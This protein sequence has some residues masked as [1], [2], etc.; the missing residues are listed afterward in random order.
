MTLPPPSLSTPTHPSFEATLALIC[1]IRITPTCY[2]TTIMKRLRNT[3]GHMVLLFV[4]LVEFLTA[5]PHSLPSG[6]KKKTGGSLGGGRESVWGIERGSRTLPPFSYNSCNYQQSPL[7]LRSLDEEQRCNSAGRRAKSSRTP[8]VP[9][10]EADG[11]VTVLHRL[12]KKKL[13]LTPPPAQRS[14]TSIQLGGAGRAK[15]V[16]L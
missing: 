3:H 1:L 8:S 2:S 15:E 7:W 11:V 9:P 6:G 16:K 14:V 10:P 4:S 12:G 5:A 13:Q